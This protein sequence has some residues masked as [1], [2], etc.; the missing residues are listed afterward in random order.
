MEELCLRVLLALLDHLVFE[1][2]FENLCSDFGG[3]I[4]LASLVGDHSLQQLMLRC[5]SLGP[6]AFLGPIS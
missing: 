2:A 3:M 5:V 1:Q 6:M 4:P